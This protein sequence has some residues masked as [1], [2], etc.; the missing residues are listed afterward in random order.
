[1][2]MWKRQRAMVAGELLAEAEDLVQRHEAFLADAGDDPM[3]RRLRADQAEQSVVRFSAALVEAVHAFH[4]GE[5]NALTQRADALAPRILAIGA[6]AARVR[7]EAADAEAA[8]LAGAR[9]PDTA[10]TG[11][12]WDAVARTMAE[13]YAAYAPDHRLLKVVVSS[14]WE[15]RTEARW[16]GRWIVGTYRYVGGWVAAELPGGGVRVYS[17][18]F[19]RTLGADGKYGPLEV[20]GVGRN[21]RMLAEN[22]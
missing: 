3:L 19:R 20:F 10:L 16:R 11:G 1:M 7:G 2:D 22:L 9:F 4:P 17:L 14:P 6:T 21:F 15:V 8:L 12:E 13:V 5:S 18:S